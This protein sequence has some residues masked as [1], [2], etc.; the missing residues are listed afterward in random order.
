MSLN[1]LRCYT[2]PPLVRDYV[3]PGLLPSTVGSIV[4]PGGQGKSMLALMIAHQIGGSVDLLGFG[5]LNTGRVVYLS[6]EDGKDILHERLYELGNRL[7]PSEKAACAASIVLEDLT[8]HTPD[9]LNGE[10]AAQWRESVERLAN[11]SRLLILDTLR[12]FH[13]GDENDNKTM[14][15]LI[16]HLRAIAART[17]C[18]IVFLHHSSKALA[19]SG[20]G[21]LQQAARGSSVLTDNIRWQS[22]LAGMTDEESK[23]YSADLDGRPIG[24]ERGYF[25]RFG[26]SKQN[27]GAPFNEK[28][29]RR[30]QGGILEP[31]TL[32]PANQEERTKGSRNND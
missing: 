1:I 19:V 17:G 16:G 28:W 25:V 29:F 2:Q 3:L 13:S 5:E 18:S 6:A 10:S 24:D 7:S 21:D 11:G 27:Y 23:R 22:Y 32:K 9:L 12:S 31:I 4:S 14:A 20:Q 30:G 26:I 15:V 8:Q